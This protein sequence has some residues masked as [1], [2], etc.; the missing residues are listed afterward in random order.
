[1]SRGPGS[2]IATVA[3][4]NAGSHAVSTHLRNHGYTTVAN[5]ISA[6]SLAVGKVFTGDASWRA[7]GNNSVLGR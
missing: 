7:V 6:Y 2:G 1:V 4:T 3:E 5:D